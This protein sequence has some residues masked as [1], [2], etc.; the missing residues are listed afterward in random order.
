VARFRTKAAAG[1]ALALAIGIV[2]FFEGYSSTPYSDPIGVPTVCYGHTGGEVKL[3]ERVRSMP[4]CRELLSVDLQRS[5]DAI[6]RY[7]TVPLEPWTRAALAS[8]IYNVGTD[9]FAT[10]T[11]LKL[12]NQ[13]RIIDACNE[14]LKWSKAGNLNLTGLVRRRIAERHLCLGEPW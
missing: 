2:G 4:Q 11:L 13:G 9:A 5:W 3:D 8:F 10:S 12:L 7:V 14:L 1:G 6:D